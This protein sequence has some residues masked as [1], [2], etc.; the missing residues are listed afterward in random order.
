MILLIVFI[1]RG[2]PASPVPLSSCFLSHIPHDGDDGMGGSADAPPPRLRRRAPMVAPGRRPRRNGA[3]NP[4]RGSVTFS[5]GVP[6]PYPR[7]ASMR[8]GSAPRCGTAAAS[9]HWSVLRR[10]PSTGRKRGSPFG[11]GS[12]RLREGD[13]PPSVL[14]GGPE[15]LR[16]AA[17]RLLRKTEPPRA[18]G[19]TMPR[20][21]ND[22]R[23][24]PLH[25]NK[26]TPMG[27]P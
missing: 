13:S 17:L 14:S 9:G 15:S 25:R 16:S 26:E 27:L 20:C 6:C 1:K 24:R 22:L 21:G 2:G 12:G 18:L 3:S 11:A 4:L 23:W 19:A 7:P 10:R 5:A 8:S